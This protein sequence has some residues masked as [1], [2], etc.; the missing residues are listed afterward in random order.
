MVF[1]KRDDLERQIRPGMRSQIIVESANK[2]TQAGRGKT[3]LCVHMCELAFWPDGG[4]LSESLFPND[5]RR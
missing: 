1:D 5:A 4:L 3:F 2:L